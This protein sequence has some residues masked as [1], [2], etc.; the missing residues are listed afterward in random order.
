MNIFRTRSPE[1]SRTPP[2]SPP[3]KRRVLFRSQSG[4]DIASK[5]S[6]PAAAG[7]ESPSKPP[8]LGIANVANVFIKMRRASDQAKPWHIQSSSGEDPQSHPGV[9]EATTSPTR[10]RLQHTD[11]FICGGAV[12]VGHLL[13]ATRKTLLEEA[14]L[15]G[16]NALVD[17]QWNCTICGPKH[18]PNGTFKVQISY[19]AFAI[20]S[21]L[22]DPHRVVALDKVKDVP[23]VMTIIKRIS[24]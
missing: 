24:E 4:S 20:R 18:R 13:R 6:P 19:T 14:E 10:E 5:T 2:A 15:M 12:N 3:S 17:E 9:V 7:P 22:A 23:G 1:A 8:P 11:I 21:D 16:A